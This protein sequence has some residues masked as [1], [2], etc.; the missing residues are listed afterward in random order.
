MQMDANETASNLFVSKKAW[1]AIT[2]P[3][4]QQFEENI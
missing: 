1:Q 3:S 2:H 4:E